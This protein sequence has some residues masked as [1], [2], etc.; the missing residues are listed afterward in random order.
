MR[1]R[2]IPANGVVRPGA[3]RRLAAVCGLALA[4]TALPA[5]LFTPARPKLTLE[6][7]TMRVPLTVNE[8]GV[9]SLNK[10][11]PLVGM[12]DLGPIYA[13]EGIPVGDTTTENL[14]MLVHYGQLYIV[15]D[16]FRAVWEIMPEPGT[17]DA[18]FRPIPI[19]EPGSEPLKDV[20][21]SQFGASE[22]A[23]VRVDHAAADPVFIL[24]DGR[25][26]A[27]CS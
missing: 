7:H 17:R 19:L 12:V 1:V 27:T 22:S 25:V 11:Q 13:A 6:H 15:A 5:C 18:A 26:H 21:L 3:R 16:G 24:A 2:S 14:Q 9:A 4:L 10:S 8:S 23:C 20:R